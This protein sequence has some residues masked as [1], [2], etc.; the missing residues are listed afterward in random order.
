MS[1]RNL[2]ERMLTELAGLHVDVAG[3]QGS[4]ES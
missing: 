1:K 2:A 4:Q 3:E